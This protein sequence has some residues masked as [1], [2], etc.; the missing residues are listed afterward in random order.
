M[1][2]KNQKLFYIHFIDLYILILLFIKTKLELSF[3]FNY[4]SSL[5]FNK[6]NDNIIISKEGIHFFSFNFTKEYTNKRIKFPFILKDSDYKKI[7]IV[8]FPDKN[9]G[10]I[11]ILV[12]KYLFIFDKEGIN[13]NS[14]N[15]FDKNDEN[16]HYSLSSYKKLGETLHF[17]IYYLESSSIILT[18]CE[19]NITN[20]E[21]NIQKIH[22][23]LESLNVEN[24][25]CLFVPPPVSLN[26]SNE[27]LTCFFTGFNE[28]LSYSFNPEVNYSRLHNLKFSLKHSLINKPN[29]MNGIINKK[30]KKV[31]IYLVLNRKPFW[32]TFNFKIGFSNIT[33]EN[34]NIILSDEYNKHKFYYLNQTDEFEI[35]SLLPNNKKYI[36]NFN[37]EFYL[38]YKKILEYNE[39]EQANFYWF[40]FNISK[41]ENNNIRN[42]E[43][44]NF[45]GDPKCK[46]STPESAVY[47]LCT[48]CNE[49]D[50]YYKAEFS[51]STFNNL[52]SSFVECYSNK[53]KPKNFYFDSGEG[54]K[55]F[56]LCYFT[57]ATCER[58]GN[59]L[60]NNCL[61][62][63]VNHIKK[64]GFPNTTNCV[65]DCLYSYYYTPYGYYKCNNNSFCPDEAN[66]YIKEEKKCTDDC[67]KEGKYKYQY[68]GQCYEECPPYTSTFNKSN[69]CLDINVDSCAITENTVDLQEFLLNGGIDV[70]AKSYA[71]EFGYTTK[72]ISH[73]YNSMYS[74]LLYKEPNC[75]EDLK[76]KMPKVDFGSC[77]IKVQN[78]LDS[79][80]NDKII[81][82]LIEKSN[83]NK[84]STTSYSF[85]HPKTGE[86]LEAE[87]IC[88]NEQIVIKKNVLSQLNNTEVDL[89][90]I[91]FLA[92]QD[93]D[94]FNRSDEFYT[95]ICY[96]FESP[97]GKDVP[98][99][100]RIHT[101]YPNVTLCEP[102]CVSKGVN[103]TSMESICECK[104]TSIINND[105]IGD[106]VLLSN[107]IGEIADLL[108]SSNLIVLKCYKDAF[109]KEYILKSTGGFIILTIAILEII[110]ILVFIFY[111]MVNI[112]KYLYNLSEYYILLISDKQNNNII[113][114]VLLTGN[115]KIKPN[116]IKKLKRGKTSKNLDSALKLKE[117]LT[118]I[119]SEKALNNYKADSNWKLMDS[120]TPKKKL[121]RA[122]SKKIEIFD[123]NDKDS[124]KKKSLEVLKVKKNCGDIN[125]E[126][127][128]KPDLDDME[129]DDAIKL[130]QRTFCQFLSDRLK[131][132]QII[133]DTFFNKENL[134]PMSIKIMLLL[135]NI[136][137]YFVVNGFFFNEQ[138]I[139]L[140][141]N[142][143]EEETFFSY[144]PRSYSRFFYCTL[145]GVI[146]SIIIDC[147]FIEEK[148]I[149][150]I[151]I[152]EKEN[153]MQ[154]RYEVSL[155]VNDIKT[156]YN[157]F[158]F[159][160]LFIAIISWYYVSCFN[161]T[162]PG[163]KNEWIKSSLTI[164]ILMQIL[165]IF[166][167][168]LQAILRGISFSCKS[169]KVYKMNQFLS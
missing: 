125:M 117:N 60:I 15:L 29:Y 5:I 66:L 41:S 14:I 113:D 100:D 143:T 45:L 133:M 9:D 164:I 111:D 83:G 151:F 1:N 26:I 75:I 11:L 153:P 96:H 38:N 44:D 8:Q 13:I 28:I 138:Y 107:A 109:K 105:F 118:N 161:N 157:V 82:A 30:K 64:P 35:V 74:I 114:N 103:Y 6:N 67:S 39:E 34:E 31:L 136:D 167:A 165:S 120:T 102:S 108:S 68:G 80:I 116:P 131:E 10:Y 53:T 145:V 126:E 139:S 106:N 79:S 148:K 71:K 141:F 86:K 2:L 84:P 99:A 37:S 169:E 77:Y 57:C 92:K 55:K 7:S 87:E 101:F 50:N 20:K 112:R 78:S 152:R 156:R 56:K 162:Y 65:T 159:L 63:D 94:I 163:V 149:K 25:S 144:I 122:K 104:F 69:I 32:I 16:H 49:D 98:L 95:D 17:I 110:F 70:N 85:Y 19:Y 23:H 97:N 134:R 22:F 129:Y 48:S 128:L 124:M 27:I 61:E 168:L 158:S 72:H 160:C 89:N 93:I 58:G 137:L 88:R 18:K 73:F 33:Q 24:T 146:I 130:D 62:C 47:K 147:V 4:L 21:I 42:L 46:T 51:N 132:K 135:V 155:N 36:M 166:I 90:S 52:N 81:I 150:R 154:I 119:N 40:D 12:K 91:L 115:E 140:L 123:F 59:G 3:S 142:S 127:Y 54:E 76:V 121:R 43:N